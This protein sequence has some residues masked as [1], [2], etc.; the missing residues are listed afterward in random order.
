[1]SIIEFINQCHPA[2]L[3]YIEEDLLSKLVHIDNL[4]KMGDGIAE[5]R[6]AIN[7]ATN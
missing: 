4:H 2:T 7:N 6:E 5:M 3:D 1:M